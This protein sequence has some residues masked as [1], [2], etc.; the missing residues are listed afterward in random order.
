MEGSQ[1]IKGGQL[2]SAVDARNGRLPREEEFAVE[3]YIHQSVSDLNSKG[4]LLLKFD[5]P[6]SNAVRGILPLTILEKRGLD[7]RTSCV[8]AD[9]DRLTAIGRC[10]WVGSC[11]G[12]IE[13]QANASPLASAMDRES[14]GGIEI[15]GYLFGEAKDRTRGAVERLS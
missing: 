2:Q 10:G 8:G 14:N 9:V 1:G 5:R 12:R 13:F 11:R 7:F 15:A 4:I 6:R 3:R